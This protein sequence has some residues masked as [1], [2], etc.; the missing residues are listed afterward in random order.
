MTAQRYLLLYAYTACVY[1]ITFTTHQYIKLT[2][3]AA[4]WLDPTI[5]LGSHDE[6]S[7]S[8]SSARVCMDRGIDHNTTDHLHPLINRWMQE[9]QPFLLWRAGCTSN[10]GLEWKITV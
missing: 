2:A 6:T 8:L 9:I 3:I 10:S 7:Q 5:D 1:D 4:Y